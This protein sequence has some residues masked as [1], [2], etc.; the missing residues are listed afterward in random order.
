MVARGLAF[1]DA[2]EWLAEK[3]GLNPQPDGCVA[4]LI[5]KSD[6]EPPVPA[7]DNDKPRSVK[8]TNSKRPIVKDDSINAE[9]LMGIKFAPVAYVV[10]RYIVEGTT[11]LG[12]KPKLGKSWLALDMGVAVATG[13]KFAGV[14]DCEKGDVLYLALEDNQRRAQSRLD[15]L[16]PNRKLMGVSLDRLTVR[17]TAPT[18]DN[19]LL[20]E[21][22]KW[23]IGC[24]R[25]RLIVIDVFMKIEPVRKKSEDPYQADYAAM[26]RLQEYASEH[27]LAIVLVTHTRKMASD[28]P[29]EA[30]SGTNGVT[31]SADS[32]LVLVRGSKGTTLYGRGRDISKK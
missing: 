32:T 31:G 11:M 16:C 9:T 29:L 28:D 15:I 20:D 14:V 1:E 26:T 21:L 23:R 12:G 3:L 4:R 25:P 8:A 19:G 6:C 27:R 22:D 30:I 13:G 7:N 24:G 18:I 5:A 17:T 2:S 10:P